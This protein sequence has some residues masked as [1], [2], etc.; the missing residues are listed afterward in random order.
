MYRKKK[1]PDY[2]EPMPKEQLKRIIKAF[3]RQGG[4][5]VI[6]DDIDKRLESMQ[7]EGSTFDATTIL[8]HSKPSRSAV[9]EKLIH[10]TQYRLG[11]NDGTEL[12]RILNE[13]E[14]QKKLIKYKKAYKIT[15]IEDFN[16][17]KALS[18][19]IQKYKEYMTNNQK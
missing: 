4:L 9:F 18:F 13:I 7:A 6:S 14:A 15:D 17:K 2:I 10:A 16:T 5:I 11:K 1:K 8:L 12:S 19:Y 3:K